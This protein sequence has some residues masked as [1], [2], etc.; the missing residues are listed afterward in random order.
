[1]TFEDRDILTHIEQ[2]IGSPARAAVDAFAA[3]LPPALVEPFQRLVWTIDQGTADHCRAEQARVDTLVRAH[4]AS[5]AWYA[6]L[7]NHCGGDAPECCEH[8]E[9][10]EQRLLAAAPAA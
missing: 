8:P 10:P 6:L 7:L 3:E 9:Q 5:G 4:L 2:A 1:M